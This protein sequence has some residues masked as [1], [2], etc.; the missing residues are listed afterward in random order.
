VSFRY[1]FRIIFMVLVLF[2]LVQLSS[3][4][5]FWQA[6]GLSGRVAPSLAMDANSNLLVGADSTIMRSTNGGTNWTQQLMISGATI[7]QIVTAPG[8]YAYAGTENAGFYR[9]TD[10]GITWTSSNTNQPDGQVRAVLVLPSGN[11]LIGTSGHGVEISTDHGQSWTQTNTGLTE[12]NARALTRTPNGNIF[13]SVKGA[14]GIFISTNNGASWSLTSMTRTY[15]VY[16]LASL[17][18]GYIYAGTQEFPNGIYRS[19]D[20][21]STWTQSGFAGLTVLNVDDCYPPDGSNYCSAY[22]Y[23]VA[24]SYNYGT[25][26]DSVNTGLTLPIVGSII[27]GPGGYL[28]AGTASGVFRSVNQITSVNESHLSVPTQFS[29]AQ[30]FPNPFNPTTR[31]QFEIPEKSFVNMKLFNLGGQEVASLANGEFQPGVHEVTVSGSELASGAYFYKLTAGKFTAT[32]T[33][34]L[35]K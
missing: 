8:N 22:P 28:Y 10:N 9:S 5:N 32:R 27:I 21:G 35:V 12:S 26:W 34:Q 11:V 4:Q 29:L 19:T 20:G 7:N 25:T 30:N 33:L 17:P 2:S 31:I 14:N 1:C 23:G 15:R 24:R 16:S 3:A 6:A 13:V 18:N